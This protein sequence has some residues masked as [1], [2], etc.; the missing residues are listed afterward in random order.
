MNKVCRSCGISKPITSFQPKGNGRRR[1]KCYS[2][3]PKAKRKPVPVTLEK[4]KADRHRILED[5]GL[6][7][8][9]TILLSEN[10]R[11]SRIVETMRAMPAAKPIVPEVYKP[12]KGEAVPLIM[13]SDLHLEEE[14]DPHKMQGLN[15]FNLKIAAARMKCLFS[16][17][18]KLIEIAAKDS[19]I[20]RV[21]L[22]LGGD[23]FSGN[24]HDELLETAQ[25]GP[26]R[27]VQFARD[28]LVGGI[29]FILAQTSVDII[30]PCVV[31]NHGRITKKLRVAT[32]VENNLEYLLYQWLAS[33]YAKNKRVRFEVCPGTMQ[34]L[35]LFDD[36]R[37][38][39]VHGYEIKSGGGIGGITIPI[40]KKLAQWDKG[41]QADLTL[42]HHFHQRMDGGDF[43]VNGSLI[44]Y[45]EFSQMNGFS[46]E[47]PQQQFAL[48][49]SRNGGEKATVSPIWVTD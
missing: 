28:L 29:D 15:E 38:R 27:A 8:Q 49:H 22:D 11:L 25:L 3:R 13:V 40:R 14:V 36:Y 33:H 19:T 45:N 2:C 43:L 46:P 16:R 1:A 21:V 34:Y 32:A 9:V 41:I 44:G 4:I 18:T 10:D 42:I 31:G 37:I 23:M 12:C 20:R 5:N 47:P 48:I 7:Q 17:A 30:V 35:T 39:I 24:I 26:T 6:R